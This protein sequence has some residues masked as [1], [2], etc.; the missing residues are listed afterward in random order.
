MASGSLAP[1]LH[2]LRKVTTPVAASDVPD[3]ELLSRFSLHRDEAAFTTLVRRHGPMVL[4]VCRR[5][6]RDGH[7]AED[8]FQATFLVLARKA[9]SLARPELLGHFLYGVAYRTAAKAKTEAAK[10]RAREQQAVR[11]QEIDPDD[12]LMRQE[13]RAVLDEEVNRLPERYRLP[14]VLCYLQGHTN[15]EAAHR[16]GCSRGTIA[17]LLARA[18]VKLRRRL[19]QRGVGL[20]A[21]ITLAAL[22][23]AVQ[24]SV[25]SFPLEHVTVKAST[26][27]AA[28][29]TQAAGA[30]VAQAVALAKGVSKGMLIEKL[31]IPA[32]IL[33]LT[34][35]VGTGAGITAYCARAQ[36]S[37]SEAPAEPESKSLPPVKTERPRKH[38][39]LPAKPPK[40]EEALFRTENFVVT[41]P[42]RELA[43]QVGKW[44][45]HYR[46]N[47]AIEWIGQKMPTWDRPCPLKVT[48]TLNGSGGATSFTFDRGQILSIDMHIEGEADRLIAD[49]LPHE[50]THTVLAYYFRTPVPRWADE[51]AAM[52]SESAA[53]RAR[54]ERMMAKVIDVERLLP[55]RDL[56]RR[57]HF[58]KDT[59]AF[60]VQ[61]LSLT[62]FLVWS[63]GR[64]NFLAFVA[65]GER[66]G[67]DE[68]ARSNYGYK[69]VEEL[70]RAWLAHA[71]EQLADKRDEESSLP[72]QEARTD[73]EDQQPNPRPA[74]A[75]AEAAPASFK[76]KLPPGPAPI[77]ALV[78]REEDGR[79]CVS[80]KAAYYQPVSEE[81]TL[82]NGQ[83]H[84]VTYYEE[85]YQDFAT[86]YDFAKVRVH[87]TKGRWIEAKE[88]RK[89]LQGET[90]VLISANGRPV[91]PRYLRL[92]KEDILV[93]VL[94]SQA[95]LGVPVRDPTSPLVPPA[96]GTPVVPAPPRPAP[97][98]PIPA[99]APL[100]APV[101]DP[102]ESVPLSGS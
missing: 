49:I 86:A 28:G 39:T 9:G 1:V 60:F 62:D 81:V 54:H 76:E 73:R 45:E 99:P 5:V 93:F 12:E 4:A 96:I 57:H 75:W 19:T 91:N 11:P 68:A 64:K 38:V 10:R 40:D 70:E 20:S 102:E 61:S 67:W 36:E 85:K 66:D 69:T 101:D 80:R 84:R 55:L 23:Q 65:Q 26:L 44:A 3:A 6:L 8:A 43:E 72:R 2:Y 63:G 27:L 47:K 46:R 7:T 13:L 89:R 21:G 87:D 17:T 24:A 79:L 53:S 32:A 56:L 29:Q 95:L 31:K 22:T 42:T 15:E 98:S 82:K 18:R 90:L 52:L 48:V 33:L 71:R 83:K 94:P 16:L 14:V 25:V 92:Y 77:Q 35:L 37:T 58:P 59:A 34:A 41:A 100:M 74:P 51:G 97:S 30:L 78:R 50:I 88:V